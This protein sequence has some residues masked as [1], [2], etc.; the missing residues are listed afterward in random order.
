MVTV[1]S[2]RGSGDRTV[3]GLGADAERKIVSIL[4]VLNESSEP[5]GS[6]AIA[7]E[8]ERYGIFLNQR[9]VRYYLKWTDERG[10]TRPLG[11]DG[12][13]LTPKGLEEQKNALAPQQIGFILDKLQMLA[14]NT[15][16]EPQK[17][18]GLVPIDVSLI[19]KDRFRDARGVMAD[20]IKSGLCLTEMVAIAGEGEKLG[21]VVIPPGKVG[22]GTVC[23]V[24]VNGLL[25]KSGVPVESRFGGVLEVENG[26][27]KRFVAIIN[28]SGTSLD[29]SEQYVRARMTS[30][31]ETVRTGNGKILSSFC[32]IPSPT[33]S[34]VEKKVAQLKQAGICAVYVLG[35]AGEPVCQI[36][37]GVNRVGMVLLGGLN[38]MAAVVESGIPVEN[39]A[40]CGLIEYGELRRL[41]QL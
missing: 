14:F 15:T 26:K 12:R 3:R 38:P 8:L 10:Y 25:L 36:S 7:R 29:P 5:L 19:D 6:T 40:E 23:S 20:F 4:K 13:M 41:S 11:H 24:V 31:T 28:Y 1:H 37:V 21:P 18:A 35:N 34:L 30:V 22:L 33:R 9:T 39:I 16:F 2:R 27:P 32:E 17:R